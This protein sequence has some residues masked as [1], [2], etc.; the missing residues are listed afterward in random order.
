MSFTL[1]SSRLNAV[2]LNMKIDMFNNTAA[3]R[4]VLIFIL[5]NLHQMMQRS[6]MS[7]TMPTRVEL[8]KKHILQLSTLLFWTM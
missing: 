5:R 6:P 1:Q 3:A 7:N 4:T 8:K 2:Q